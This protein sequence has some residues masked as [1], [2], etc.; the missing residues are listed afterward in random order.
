[1]IRKG[2]K[3]EWNW[4]KGK[5]HGIVK[6]IQTHDVSKKIKGSEIKRKGSDEEPVYLI[7]QEDGDEVLKSKS[8]IKRA[9]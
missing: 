4:G 8:E 7:E 2:T 5:G 1:M 9:S 3:V 6:D